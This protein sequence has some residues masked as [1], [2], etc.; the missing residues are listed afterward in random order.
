MS[1]QYHTGLDIGTASIKA[2]VVEDR[3]HMLIPRL[4]LRETSAGMKKGAVADPA[5]LALYLERV[6]VQ[7]RSFSRSALRSVFVVIGTHQVK[8][9]NS[10][11]IVA[12]SQAGGEISRDDIERVVKASEAVNVGVNRTI[13]HNV[14]REFTV[15][16]VP[17]ITDPLGLSGSRL[18]VSSLLV[19]AFEPHVKSLLRV[20]ELAG[21]RVTG[22][23]FAPLASSAAVLSK[24]QKEIGTAVIDLGGGTT[25]LAVYEEHKLLGVSKFPVG[26]ANISRDLAVGLKIPV[27]AAEAIKLQH[28]HALAREA[29]S[30]EHVNLSEFCPGLPG[31][32]SRRVVA[33]I[34]ESRLAE[35]L[36]MVDNELKVLGKSG[37]L[38][39][40]AVLVGGGAK[41]PGLTDLARRELQLSTQIGSP[42]TDGWQM[43]ESDLIAYF[44]DPE[45][46]CSLGV[47]L[48]GLERDAVRTASTPG[49]GRFRYMLRRVLRAVMP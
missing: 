39:G 36:E 40:G 46:T 30:R 16:G 48:V 24:S 19:D 14:I 44:E 32:V 25:G 23:V 29:G 6:L 3:G 31:S 38:A 13:I 12:V 33:E 17:D 18:E 11:G 49:Q 8:A 27:A 4:F 41:M 42:L 15:D 47:L 2:V 10:R 43:G 28:G 20:V 35:I 26:S 21:G 7:V 5:E 45:F 22:L 9:Q 1:V 34:I 37:Q